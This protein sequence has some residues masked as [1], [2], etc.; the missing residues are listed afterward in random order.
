VTEREQLIL[1]RRWNQELV[2]ENSRLHE[3]L[4]RKQRRMR[5]LEEVTANLIVERDAADAALA[6]FESQQR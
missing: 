5:E 3:E 1:L 6:H 4:C 2:R